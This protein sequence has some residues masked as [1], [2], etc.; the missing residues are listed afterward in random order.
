MLRICLMTGWWGR[1]LLRDWLEQWA[2]RKKN[3]FSLLSFPT[4]WRS[5]TYQVSFHYSVHEKR[6]TLDT[7]VKYGK[8][9]LGSFFILTGKTHS[10]GINILPC[11]SYKI[12]CSKMG[13]FIY[14][15]VFCEILEFVRFENMFCVYYSIGIWEIVFFFKG[16]Y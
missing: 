12:I 16:K 14:F 13:L 15:F 8:R 7:Y 6:E 2:V 10:H 5:T 4:W 11:S 9:I 3:I 1:F